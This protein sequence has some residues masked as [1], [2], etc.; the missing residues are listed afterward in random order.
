MLASYYFLI[1]YQQ[2]RYR[3]VLPGISTYIQQEVSYYSTENSLVDRY[4]EL[5]GPVSALHAVCETAKN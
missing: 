2:K 1:H 5:T 4:K 3:E